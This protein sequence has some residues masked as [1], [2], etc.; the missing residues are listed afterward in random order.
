MRITL[1]LAQVD[2]VKLMD[3][4]I[5]KTLGNDLVGMDL[6]NDGS[7]I[8]NGAKKVISYFM[9]FEKILNCIN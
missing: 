5:T 2:I 4:K 3:L 8:N 6:K 7:Q 9:G 1:L